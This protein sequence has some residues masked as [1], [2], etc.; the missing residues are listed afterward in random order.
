[1]IISRSLLVKFP[2]AAVSASSNTL[3]SDTPSF[4]TTKAAWNGGG[5]PRSITSP[6]LEAL[7]KHCFEKLDL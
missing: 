1:M 5:R 4:E 2:T 3:R 6:M 7:L